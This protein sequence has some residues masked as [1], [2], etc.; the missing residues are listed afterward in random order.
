M[1]RGVIADRAERSDA[2]IEVL[3]DKEVNGYRLV[4]TRSRSVEH[5]GVSLSPRE[6]EIARV[7]AKGHVNKTIAGVLDISTWKVGTHLRRIFAKFA[8]TSR[9]AMVA[10]LMESVATEYPLPKQR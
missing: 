8:V 10:R 1:R 7:I 5:G 9:A 2:T 4:V 3:V 6:L